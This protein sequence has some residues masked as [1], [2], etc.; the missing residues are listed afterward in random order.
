LAP[1]FAGSGVAPQAGIIAIK[2]DSM[3]ENKKNCAPAT[4]CSVFYDSDILRGLDFVYRKRNAFNIASINA[5]LGGNAT[6]RECRRS[7]IQRAVARLRVANIATVVAS[8]ND[9]NPNRLS[10]PA[11]IPGVISVGSTD[12]FDLVSSFS[13]NSPGLSLL[14]PG[15][16]IGVA[17]PG[18]APA[19]FEVVSSGTSLSAAFVSGAWATLK[20]QRPFASVDE[21]LAALIGTGVPSSDPKN[22]GLIKPR[23]QVNEALGL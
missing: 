23:I 21:I 1:G 15:E 8:G 9:G 4:R 18:V 22:S 6:R 13:N 20:A 7:P 19:G 5:S 14:A 10:S 16:D 17:I 2:A 11:C 3:I 12:A